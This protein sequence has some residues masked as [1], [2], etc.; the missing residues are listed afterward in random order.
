MLALAHEYNIHMGGSDSNAQVRASYQTKIRASV[1]PW[2]LTTC[3]FLAGCVYNAYYL[4]KLIHT[5]E[6]GKKITHEDFQH[7]I[8]IKL[9]ENPKVFGRKRSS[10]VSISTTNRGFILPETHRLVKMS[11]KG[12]CTVCKTNKER[13]AKRQAVVKGDISPISLRNDV[14]GATL[15]NRG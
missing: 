6:V 1:W 4:Y 7:Q 10:K 9:L 3:L 5:D 11:K 8:A 15:P 14:G 12:Y 13:P 2:S